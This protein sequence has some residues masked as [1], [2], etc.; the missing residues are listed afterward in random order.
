MKTIERSSR[1]ILVDLMKLPS[2]IKSYDI[3]EQYYFIHEIIEKLEK[4]V[5][6]L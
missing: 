1:E 6:Y 3:D 4:S 2:N 5:F